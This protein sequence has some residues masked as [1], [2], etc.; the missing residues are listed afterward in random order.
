VGC[1]TSSSPVAGV[2]YATARWA[3]LTTLK[4]VDAAINFL[5]DSKRRQRSRGTRR[6]LGRS[7]SSNYGR[8]IRSGSSLPSFVIMSSTLSS[9]RGLMFGLTLV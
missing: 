2:D 7:R 1:G 4:D 9:L 3:Y 5:M 8:R 6:Q